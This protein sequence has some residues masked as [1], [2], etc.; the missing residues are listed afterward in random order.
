[1]L[2]NFAVGVSVF[3]VLILKYTIIVVSYYSG[4]ALLHAAAKGGK[5]E[6]T[7]YRARKAAVRAQAQ[8]QI[9]RQF[10]GQTGQREI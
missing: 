9:R 3:D 1:M 2:R 4:F 6:K 7:G 10:Q 8:C 5:S